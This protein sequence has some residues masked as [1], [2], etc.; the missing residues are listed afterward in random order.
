MFDVDS[1][2]LIHSD[3]KLK[4]YLTIHVNDGLIV[5]NSETFIGSV[6]NYLN[7]GFEIMAT[8]IDYYLGLQIERRSDGSICV[9]QT[10]YATVQHGDMQ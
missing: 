9:H 10:N 7:G 8:N 4:A 6:I 1:C 2:V 3:E 5:S